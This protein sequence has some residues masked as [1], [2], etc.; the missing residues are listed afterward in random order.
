M[1]SLSASFSSH[2]SR[3][4]ASVFTIM[5]L[6]AIGAPP[7]LAQDNGGSQASKKEQTKQLKKNYA[8]G[9]EAGN[10]GNYEMAATKFEAAL[11]LAKQ[12]EL[13][14]TTQK[15]QSNL[16]SSLKSAGSQ[17][18]KNEDYASALTHFEKVLEY[19]DQD[20]GVY[21]NRGLALINMDSTRTALQS[22]QTAIQVG[23][24]TG[25]T[26]VA[27]LATERIRD[28]FLNKAST[29]LS[30]ENPSSAKIDTALTT[31]DEMRNYV[32]PSA[33]TL[34]YRSLALFEQGDYQDAVST[35]QK[36]LEMHQGSRSDAAKYHF[37]I[38]E[39]QM[40]LGNKQSACETFKNAAFGD[41]K[42]RAEHYLENEC[43]N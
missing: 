38:A 28:H 10:N 5:L 32:N 33:Q 20:P 11:Q 25:N 23:N 19:T 1:T 3:W 42:A 39:S 12:L 2:L 13:G 9:A 34:F 14:S 8:E 6:F 40:D 16:V 30:A 29:A 27:G 35:A 24:E 26:K 22:M 17:A 37:V 4:S 31:L 18:L 41:Y 36:G 21:H 43:K 7:T 15:I